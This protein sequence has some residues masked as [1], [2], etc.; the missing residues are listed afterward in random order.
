MIPAPNAPQRPG[1]GPALG[2]LCL[3]AMLIV[4]FVSGIPL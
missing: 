2:V 1:E 3:V 4:G